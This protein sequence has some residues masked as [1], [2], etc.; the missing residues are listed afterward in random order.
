[1]E[2]KGVAA[3]AA[4]MAAVGHWV[5]VVEEAEQTA[6]ELTAATRVAGSMRQ[7]VTGAA[8]LAWAVC[9]GAG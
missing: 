9:L 7:E 3:R 6:A 5:A 1:M 4:L 8:T 2:G